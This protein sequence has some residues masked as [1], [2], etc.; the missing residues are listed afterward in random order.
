M[1]IYYYERYCD[2]RSWF[3]HKSS[4][5]DQCFSL[6]DIAEVGFL[7]HDIRT[8]QAA[9]PTGSPLMLIGVGGWSGDTC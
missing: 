2:E 7:G 9:L 1:F 8:G 3:I 6:G 4:H 5:K